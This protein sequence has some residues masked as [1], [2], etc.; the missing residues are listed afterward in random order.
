MSAHPDVRDAKHWL[1]FL[2]SGA[3]AF[4]VDGATMKLL[5]HF[6]GMP[7]LASRLIGIT[8]AM[9]A[10]WL[11]HRH[12]TFRLATPPSITEFVKYAGV[13][14]TAA[15]INYVCFAGIL[16]VWPAL[17]PLIALLASSAVAMGAAY[18]G[19]RF[20]AFRRPKV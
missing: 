7:I 19:M 16:F 10:G 15:A 6:F 3:I 13:A 14:W 8:L 9:V 17:E 2:I 4:A 1:G 20:A 12:L 5:T 11:A 18:L